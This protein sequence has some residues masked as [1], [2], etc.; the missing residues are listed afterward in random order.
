M[1]SGA[2]HYGTAEELLDQAAAAVDVD[3]PALATQLIARAQVHA[4]LAQ[5]A[6]LSSLDSIGSQRGRHNPARA[7]PPPPSG[8][9]AT[10]PYAAVPAR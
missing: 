5:A 1:P 9:I 8:P 10:R 4:T 3:E 6:A 2:Y 7:T